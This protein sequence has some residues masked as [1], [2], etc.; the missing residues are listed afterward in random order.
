[1]TIY[2]RTSSRAD[3]LATA[4][5]SD[6]NGPTHISTIGDGIPTLTA[7]LLDGIVTASAHADGDLREVFVILDPA[8]VDDLV[9]IAG[10]NRTEETVA[11]L[12]KAIRALVGFALYPVVVHRDAEGDTIVT[13]TDGDRG[14]R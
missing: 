6:P 3:Q 5:H 8:I 12:E 10:D 1:M 13:V 9:K 7:D 4:M 11:R 14:N 2:P